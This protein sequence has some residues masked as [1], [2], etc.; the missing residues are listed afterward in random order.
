MPVLEL[1]S[2][3]A[4]FKRTEEQMVHLILHQHLLRSIHLLSFRGN[5]AHY[6]ALCKAMLILRDINTL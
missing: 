4:S 5:K 3:N 2:S 6:P 1:T